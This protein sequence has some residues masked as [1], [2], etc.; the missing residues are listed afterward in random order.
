MRLLLS[1]FCYTQEFIQIA[2]VKYAL[3]LNES[4]SYLNHHVISEYFDYQSVD[5]HLVLFDNCL[6]NEEYKYKIVVE[7]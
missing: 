7:Q 2:I 5:I 1:D 3:I 4:I 6:L